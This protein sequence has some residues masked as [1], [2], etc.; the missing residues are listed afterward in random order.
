MSPDAP[1]PQAPHPDVHVGRDGWL[2]LVGGRNRVLAQYGTPGFST[3]TLWRWRWLLANRA[4]RCARLNIRF[5]HVVAPEKLS[6][7]PGA[8]DGLALD[9][10]RSPALRLERWL[11]LSIARGAWINLVDPFRTE[12]RAVPLYRRTDSH[13]TFAGSLLAYRTICRHLGVAPRD[14]VEARRTGADDFFVTGDLGLKFDPPVGEVAESCLFAS[15]ARRTHAN[16]L[17]LGLEAEGRPYDAHIG[18]HVVFRNEAAPDP[19]RLV[20][21]GDSYAHHTQN[22][23]TGTLTPLFAD[24][25]REVHMLWSTSVDWAYLERVRPDFVVTQIAERFMIDVPQRNFSID[26]LAELAM[27]RKGI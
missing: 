9:A 23:R 4:R 27:A 24:T 3:A 14:D 15:E 22:P 18:A 20:V 25:F 26:R 19:R 21:F 1:A 2:F 16:R 12:S 7:Q 10:D 17:L 8:L 6:V 13:W 5:A 11:R